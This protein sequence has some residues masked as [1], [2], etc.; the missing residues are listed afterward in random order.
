LSLE[1]KVKIE[2]LR[3]EKYGAEKIA[4]I[5]VRGVRTIEREMSR[6][7]VKQRRAIRD[8]YGDIVGYKE[9]YVYSAEE[10]ERKYKLA[11]TSKGAK[12]KLGSDYG[13]SEFIENCIGV[14]RLSPY[15]TSVKI[16]ENESLKTKLHWKTIYNY[17]DKDL[18]LTISN[19]D[20]WVKKD[21]KTREYRQIRPAHNNRK[22]KLITERPREADE[23]SEYGHWEMDCV[24]G[25]QGTKAALLVLTERKTRYEK[26]FKLSEKTQSE[27][28]R[29][30]DKLERDYGTERFRENFKTLT[31][32]NGSEFLCGEAIEKSSLKENA[33]RTRIYY[34]HPYCASERGSNENQNKMIRRFIPKGTDIGDYSEEE[35]RRIEHYINTYPRRLFE[36]YPSKRQYELCL[37]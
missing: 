4:E 21:A 31:S 15:A 8:F 14:E 10:S 16:K 6:G 23:R 32:D 1:E 24:V 28:L 19:K 27:V 26:I 36:G 17:L 3:K 25:K 18:F 20:L 7:K 13:L 30:L 22:G 11:S 2:V 33:K 5:L 9:Y 34:C 35:L 12:L 37:A 29:V